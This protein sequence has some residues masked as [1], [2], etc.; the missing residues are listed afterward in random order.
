[1]AAQSH[2]GSL[3]DTKACCLAAPKVRRSV[4]LEAGKL[5][6]TSS[7]SQADAIDPLAPVKHVII[8]T[9]FYGVLC[10]PLPLLAQ[11]DP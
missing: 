3:G 11:E 1:M 2:P 4:V 9:L 8:L 6:S 5:M 10:A 7:G